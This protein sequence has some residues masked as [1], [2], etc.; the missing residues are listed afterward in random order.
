MSTALRVRIALAVTVL[1]WSAAFVAIRHAAPA[2]P[3]GAFLLLRFLLPAVLL[4]LWATRSRTILPPRGDRR[5]VVLLGAFFVLYIG[6]LAW[7]ERTLDAGTASMLA[8]TSP[9]LTYALAAVVLREGSSRPLLVGLLVSFAG[10]VLIA[11]DHGA[12]GFSLSP[13]ALLVL[14]AAI[15]QALMFIVQKPLLA[16]QSAFQVVTQATVVGAVATAPFAA[17][18]VHAVRTAPAS[19][20]WAIVFLALTTGLVSYVTLAYAMA[21]SDSTGATSSVLYLVPPGAVLI[22][23]ALLGEVPGPWTVLGGVLAIAGVAIAQRR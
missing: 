12:G 7:G 16:R 18:L 5:A 13:G 22:S 3:I 1:T 2:Y 15:A 8:E 14:G 23:W 17:Q 20:T 10:A 19:A 11:R 6:L 21:R 9:I 4:G